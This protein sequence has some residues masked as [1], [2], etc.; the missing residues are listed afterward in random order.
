MTASGNSTISKWISK[1][2]YHTL[3]IL[4]PSTEGVACPLQQGLYPQNPC[5]FKGSDPWGMFI[6]LDLEGVIG[7]SYGHFT[8]YETRGHGATSNHS[9]WKP[10]NVWSCRGFG[11][12]KSGEIAHML[13]LLRRCAFDIHKI[14]YAHVLKHN[15]SSNVGQFYGPLWQ[16]NSNKAL[17]GL[18]DGKPESQG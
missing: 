15:E 1:F 8:F 3:R 16:D 14:N 13:G 17:L 6:Y 7:S 4:G 12:V 5:F 9:C 10:L 18:W 2:N 11:C